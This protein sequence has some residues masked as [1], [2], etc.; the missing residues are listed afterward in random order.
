MSPFTL[1]KP[2]SS[3]VFAKVGHR[4]RLRQGRNLIFVHQVKAQDG[5][6]KLTR[7]GKAI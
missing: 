1:A 6:F 7:L 5:F 4:I 3:R 2:I